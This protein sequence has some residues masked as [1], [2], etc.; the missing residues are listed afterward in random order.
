MTDD[1]AAPLLP[2]GS[3]ALRRWGVDLPS[4]IAMGVLLGG[5]IIWMVVLAVRYPES[6]G[7]SMIVII[8]IVVLWYFTA[9]R[10]C[11]WL[12][13]TEVVAQNNFST[14]RLPRSQVVTA[15]QSYYGLIILTKDGTSIRSAAIR[16]PAVNLIPGIAKYAAEVVREIEAWAEERGHSVFGTPLDQIVHAKVRGDERPWLSIPT[17]WDERWT[18]P[19]Q[20]AEAMAPMASAQVL[21]SYAERFGGFDPTQPFDI[22]TYLYLPDPARRPMPVQVWVDDL[23][24]LSAAKASEV[25]GS[26]QVETETFT[27]ASLGTG[28]RTITHGSVNRRPGDP[29]QPGEEWTTV[30]YAFAIPGHQAVVTVEGT[31]TDLGPTSATLAALD[32]L[33]R[34][35]APARADGTPVGVET[36][37]VG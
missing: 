24:G 15:E 29:L 18:G 31:D 37:T 28:R 32:D 8:L 6:A 5:M 27:T 26:G 3:R 23:E 33:V 36:A 10:P 9:F 1:Q 11:L 34:T 2:D 4:Q 12:S 25:Q 22:A 7:L 35:I 13:E 14:Q 17:A 16:T 19:Q 30:R 21:R 20:W